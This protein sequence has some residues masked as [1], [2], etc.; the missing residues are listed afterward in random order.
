MVRIERMEVG[1]KKLVYV[2]EFDASKVETEKELCARLFLNAKE[3]D[4]DY[5]SRRLEMLEKRKHFQRNVLVVI[6]CL[7]GI[8]GFATGVIALYKWLL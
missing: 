7:T 1:G 5:E 3:E 8:I 4:D 6:N 2:G